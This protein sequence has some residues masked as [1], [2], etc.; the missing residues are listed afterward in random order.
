MGPTPQGRQSL[1]ILGEY[2]WNYIAFNN[3]VAGSNPATS[4]TTGV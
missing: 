2:W 3:V 4:T 1:T